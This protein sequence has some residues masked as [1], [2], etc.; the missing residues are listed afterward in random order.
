MTRSPG[1]NTPTFLPNRDSQTVSQVSAA[2]PAGTALLPYE[3]PRVLHIDEIDKSDVD[4]PNDCSTCLKR[5]SSGSRNW[6]V[7]PI[8]TVSRGQHRAGRH[9]VRI[10]QGTVRC[11]HSRSL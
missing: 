1:S 7:S 5:V 3:R 9:R 2:R 11:A 8:L 10:E 4:L 6:Y